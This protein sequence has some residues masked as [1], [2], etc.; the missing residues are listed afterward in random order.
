MS[1][2]T[3]E[4]NSYLNG[5]RWRSFQ[6]LDDQFEE[7]L[8]FEMVDEVDNVQRLRNLI[9]ADRNSFKLSAG[10][11]YIVVVLCLAFLHVPLAG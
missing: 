6:P 3:H 7:P 5:C 11:E 2:D 10:E 9:T 4:F 1:H 8:S